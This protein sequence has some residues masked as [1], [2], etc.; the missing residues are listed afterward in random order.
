MWHQMCAF[1]RQWLKLKITTLFVLNR[2]FASGFYGEK[3]T[4]VKITFFLLS[5][6]SA[7]APHTS[8]GNLRSFVNNPTV[9][10]NDWKINLNLFISKSLYKSMDKAIIA[11]LLILF[12]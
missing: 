6:Q 1:V 9:S 3:I 2:L 12:K 8:W 11:I 5:N 10:W 4:V 7:N